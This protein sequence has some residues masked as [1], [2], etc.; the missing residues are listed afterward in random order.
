MGHQKAAF[1]I[2]TKLFTPGSAVQSPLGRMVVKWYARFDIWVATQG[3]FPTALSQ[4]W[5]TEM[6]SYC[7]AQAA[8]VTDDPV[9]EYAWCMEKELAQFLVISRAMSMLYARRSRDQIEPSDYEAEHTRLLKVSKD[10]RES[11]SPIIADPN[12]RVTVFDY[13]PPK[14]EADIIDPHAPPQDLYRSHKFATTG[15]IM[16]YLSITIMHKLQSPPGVG[17]SVWMELA[18]HG[19]EVCQIF[20][21]IERFPGSPAGS[22]LFLHAPLSISGLVTPQDDKHHMWFRRKFALLESKG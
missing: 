17:Q 19:Y 2:L 1:E 15:L 22:L 9:M 4:D 3:G 8:R 16:H 6:M 18:G 12:Y 7:Q 11:W 10:W 21:Q 14:T 13:G 20:E 5:L